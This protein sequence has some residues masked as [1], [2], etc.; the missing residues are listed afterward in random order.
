MSA[1]FGVGAPGTVSGASGGKLYAFN[2]LDATT[3]LAVAPANT[4]RRKITFHNPGSVDVFIFPQ[5]V[6]TTGSNVANTVTVSVLGGAIRVFSNGGQYTLE[7]ECQGA[8]YALAAEGS[9]HPFTV[10]DTNIG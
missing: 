8:W 4:A 1:I 5:Y 3:P 6:Q 9:G 10:I 2:T 7:G